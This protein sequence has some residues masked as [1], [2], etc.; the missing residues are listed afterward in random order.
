MVQY[1]GVG[2]REHRKPRLAMVAEPD[3]ATPIA[4]SET[5]AGVMTHV[6]AETPLLAT[7]LLSFVPVV[8]SF[9]HKNRPVF[10]ICGFVP[11]SQ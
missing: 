4:P 6:L 1:R 10:A 9:A 8:V 5:A 3:I 2:K 7:S 11:S